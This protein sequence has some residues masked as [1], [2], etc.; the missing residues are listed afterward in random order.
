[1]EGIM[2]SFE[3]DVDAIELGEHIEVV[4]ITRDDLDYMMTLHR[5]TQT[6]YAVDDDGSLAPL[7]S[8]AISETARD[9][10][11]GERVDT[12]AELAVEKAHGGVG[13]IVVSYEGPSGQ[14]DVRRFRFT[15]AAYEGTDKTEQAP[16]ALPAI[17][18]G[19]VMSVARASAALRSPEHRAEVD[20]KEIRV[21]G[22]VVRSTID[23]VPLCAVHRAGIEDPQGCAPPVPTFWLADTPKASPAESMR[24]MGWASNHAVIYDAIRLA[25]RGVSASTV[26]GFWGVTLPQPLPAVGAR[27]VIVG[28]YATKFEKATLPVPPDPVMGIL[29]ASQITTLTKAS[30]AA[31]LRGMPPAR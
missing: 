12:K 31:R 9:E 24:V 7:F 30:V 17:S 20:G 28:R 2:S 3:L 22:Y 21:A 8:E 16:I 19:T 11:T 13:D 27:L 23:E 14:H 1:V 4:S 26:D 6:L 5:K 18:E 10:E 29:D 15:G 25:D